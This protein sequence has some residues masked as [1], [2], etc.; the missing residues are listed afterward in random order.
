[1]DKQGYVARKATASTPSSTKE[2]T[3]SPAVNDAAGTPPAPTAVTPN[4]SP[5]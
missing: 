2:P 3:R 5:P 1:M 4:D